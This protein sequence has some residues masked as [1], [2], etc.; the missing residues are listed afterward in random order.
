M[1]YS[2]KKAIL[3]CPPPSPPPP[4][5]LSLLSNAFTLSRLLRLSWSSTSM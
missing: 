5:S 2:K 3:V 1:P 4:P